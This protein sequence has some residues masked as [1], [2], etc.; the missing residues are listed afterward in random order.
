MGRGAALAPVQQRARRE[1]CRPGD[2]RDRPPARLPPRPAARAPRRRA[3]PRD[4]RRSDRARARL[5]R[6]NAHR[7]EAHPRPCGRRRPVGL[8]GR[9]HADG[10][11]LR[12]PQLRAP[13]SYTLRGRIESRLAALTVPLAAALTVGGA[14]GHWWP[15]E[16]A[17]LMVG[18]GIAADV[19]YHLAL[20]Y[21]P[22]WAAV[23]LGLL[24]L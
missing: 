24:E 4:R 12:R 5:D 23:P 15:I 9:G 11:A 17:G 18:L 10:R 1:R 14:I 13:M 8:P 6:H 20:T 16:L 21:Q 3:R 2:L 7:R 22:G 19:V